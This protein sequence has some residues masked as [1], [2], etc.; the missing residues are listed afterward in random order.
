[1]PVGCCQQHPVRHLRRTI[2][3]AKHRSDRVSEP[4]GEEV[5]LSHDVA[6]P[7]GKTG[8][9][10]NRLIDMASTAHGVAIVAGPACEQGPHV[11]GAWIERQRP[12][13]L[14]V[15]V[16]E[17]ASIAESLRKRSMSLRAVRVQCQC[18]TSV[19][20]HPRLRGGI[21]ASDH[22]KRTVAPST[23]DPGAGVARIGLDGPRRKTECFFSLLLRSFLLCLDGEE[24]EIVGTERAGELAASPCTICLLYDAVPADP[25]G[26]RVGDLGLYREDVGCRSIPPLAPDMLTARRVDQLSGYPHIFVV[27]L[28]G[29][30]EHV[31][32]VSS[33]PTCR[34]S[35]ACPCTQLSSCGR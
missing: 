26:C 14:G 33:L 16:H 18:M 10:P 20:L 35:T 11:C 12:L 1:M 31:A 7:R 22:R 25:R 27:S 32:H 4:A 28:D 24:R 19:S 3:P 30:L 23:D 34:T 13:V 21:V 29:A 6:V 2:L 8:V 5:G 17:P 9:Q 15:G